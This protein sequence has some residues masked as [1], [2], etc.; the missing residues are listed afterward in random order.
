MTRSNI[1]HHEFQQFKGDR[2][3]QRREKGQSGDQEAQENEGDCRR[4]EPKAEWLAAISRYGQEEVMG[5]A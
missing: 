1:I 3:G 4:A 2:H 5:S